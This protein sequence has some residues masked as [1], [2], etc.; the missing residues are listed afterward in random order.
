M[1]SSVDQLLGQQ[2]AETSGR[3]DG[4]GSLLKRF[5]P[6]QQLG[7]LVAGGTHCDLGHLA[8]I[9]ADGHR[10]VSGLV[11]IAPNDHRHELLLVSW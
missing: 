10:R 9:A 3:L 4:P 1:L 7:R 5:S 2:V 11:G 6:R 8:F